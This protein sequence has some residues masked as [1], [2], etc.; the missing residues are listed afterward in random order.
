MK[1]EKIII[2]VLE[3][4]DKEFKLWDTF[5]DRHKLGSI[6][7]SSKWLKA[8][9]EGL[10]CKPMHL[11]VEKESNIIGCLPC[12]I[13]YI[14]KFKRLSSI[15]QGGSGFL[16]GSSMESSLKLILDKVKEFLSEEG[17]VSHRIII[18]DLQQLQYGGY[19]YKYSYKL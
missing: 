6:F 9:E 5:V 2:R 14:K 11:I 8:I 12:F 4:S 18:N 7:F 19:L 3:T 15:P 10:R 17:L 13:E 1:K 16:L